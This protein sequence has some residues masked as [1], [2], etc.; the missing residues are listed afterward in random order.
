MPSPNVS[1]NTNSDNDSGLSKFA[2]AVGSDAN[3]ILNTAGKDA[4]AILNT[5]GKDTNAILNTAGNDANA[6]LNTAGKD[7]NAIGKGIGS[8]GSGYPQGRT[9]VP[10]NYNQVGYKQA[11]S[12]QAGSQQAG[13]QQSGS[14]QTGPTASV[15][16]KGALSSPYGNVTGAQNPFTYNGALS[17]KP[18]SDF[19]PITADFSKFSK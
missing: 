3:A 13:S 5:A 1:G 8:L 17:E 19:I 12:Q 4:N 11:G 18:S 9:G 7:L 16:S 6:I 15:S 14:Q 2:N 10:Q